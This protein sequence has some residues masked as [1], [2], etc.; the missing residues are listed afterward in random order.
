MADSDYNVIK[1]VESLQTIQSVTPAKR[2]QERK[3]QPKEPQEHHDE[4]ETERD[5]DATPQATR[6]D[7]DPHSIDYCA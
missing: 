1:P 3:H 2:R 5:D 7:D 6:N 4:P